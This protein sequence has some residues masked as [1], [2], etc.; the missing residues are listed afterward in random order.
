MKTPEQ[1]SLEAR[2]RIAENRAILADVR[3]Q[4]ILRAVTALRETL[5]ARSPEFDAE[6]LKQLA[7]IVPVSVP[8]EDELSL[9]STLHSLLVELENRGAK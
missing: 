1:Q 5:A 9:P 3:S 7:K 6:Y 4:A 8:T 2:I